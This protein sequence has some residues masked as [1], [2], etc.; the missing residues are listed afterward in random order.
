MF[1]RN[2]NIAPRAFLG[3]ALIGTLMLILGVAAL[4]QMSTIRSAAVN[5][6]NSSI[7]SIRSLDDFTK[8]TY[9]LRTLSYRLL[10]NREP[11]IQKKTLEIFKLR[12][13]QI[14]AAQK[15]YEGLIQSP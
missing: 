2:L 8:I 6:E 11:E 13:E 5:I 4:T 12:N 1:L 9:R 7:P 10:L 15:I 14:D 3:F